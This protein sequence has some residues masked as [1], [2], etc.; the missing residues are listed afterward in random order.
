VKEARLEA[1]SEVVL[2]PG[3]SRTR[4]V[5]GFA[6]FPAVLGLVMAHRGS[7]WAWLWLALA[8]GLIVFASWVL[9]A[10]RMRLRLSPSGFAYGTARRRYFF[11]W[12]DV[13]YFTVREF[14]TYRHVFFVFAPGYRGDERLRAINQDFGGFD[15]FLPDTYGM[16]AEA[17]ADVLEA[18]RLRHTANPEQNTTAD[19]GRDAGFSGFTVARRGRRC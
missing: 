4:W 12:S 2:R 17:L 1:T 15:R 13:A 18:W 8:A 5:V 3:F 9:T 6:V 10:P 14:A 16:R 7:G 11:Q 19:G